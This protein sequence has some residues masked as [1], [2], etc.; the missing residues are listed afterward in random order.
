MLTP[1]SPTGH[2]PTGTLILVRH[3]Q[4][5]HNAERR[6]QGH[7]DIPL[8]D[9]GEAQAARLAAHL[10][11][12]GLSA[13]VMYASDLSR[14]RRTAEHV[15]ERV[16]GTLH[17]TP[18]LREISVGGWEGRL[19]AE[20]HDEDPHGLHEF[21]SG[22][23]DFRAPDGET[24]REVA[25]R[26]HDFALRHWPK[27]GETVVLVFHGLAITALLCELLG[28]DY[29]QE[30]QSARLMHD[31][32]AYTLLTVTEPGKIIAYDAAL[33]PHLDTISPQL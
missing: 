14:A 7:E 33:K 21:R 9:I 29:Q 16:G 4:T 10:H 31:N 27:A 26:L 13:P 32:T 19:A 3:G 2:L 22:N 28:L 15:Q 8:S 18:E 6:F 24:P 30:W 25:M 17:L 20:L 11:A 23:P 1:T 12:Q 5:A